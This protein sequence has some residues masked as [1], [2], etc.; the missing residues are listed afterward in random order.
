MASEARELAA[1]FDRLLWALEG[2][3]RAIGELLD[4]SEQER[5][6][7]ARREIDRLEQV[8][9][10]KRKLVLAIAGLEESRARAEEKCALHYGLDVDGRR[11]SAIVPYLEARQAARLSALAGKVADGAAK[12]AA[13]NR[14]NRQL[15][16]RAYELGDAA[17]R[18]LLDQSARY[19]TGLQRTLWTCEA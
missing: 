3:A 13:A 18:F 7:I 15:L 14:R 19:T 6:A 4:L 1:V 17:I 2:E 8:V 10:R 9:N 11:I 12:L 5:E 16:E